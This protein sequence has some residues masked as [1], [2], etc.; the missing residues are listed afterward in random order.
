MSVKSALVAAVVVLLALLIYR[1]AAS[2]RP[3]SRGTPLPMAHPRP[4][5]TP[6]P[7]PVFIPQK[8]LEIAKLFNGMEVRTK[9]ESEPGSTATL[10]RETPSSYALELNVKVKIPKPNGD[11]AA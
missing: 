7:T 4:T 1:E 5:P 8:K 9:V 11:L 6:K 3:W 2:R 10:E